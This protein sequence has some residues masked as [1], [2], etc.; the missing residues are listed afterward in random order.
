M[1][2]MEEN[3][4]AIVKKCLR[5]NGEAFQHI[6]T[7][8]KKKI[9]NIAY[10]YTGNAQDALDITQE[11]FIK[12][13][14]SLNTYNFSYKFSS[15]ILKIATN[16][17]LDFKKKKKIDVI[18]LKPELDYGDS[19]HSPEA[20]LLQKENKNTIED[21]IDSLPDKYRILIIM[22]H[23]Q[24]MSYKEISDILDLPMTKVKNRL[25]RGRLMLKE[26]IKNLREEEMNWIAKGQKN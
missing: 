18:P 26:K 12:A 21:L 25:Y 20:V 24:N 9:Y 6:V 23:T 13:Y 15:W 3:D 10:R 8:Y 14:D 22:Y 2:I 11:V 16:Y 1:K 17:C 4:A 5:G 19:I 7:K